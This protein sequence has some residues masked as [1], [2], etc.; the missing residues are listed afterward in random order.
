MVSRERLNTGELEEEEE[1]AAA[2]AA[3]AVEEEEEEEEN[4]AIARTQRG[5]THNWMGGGCSHKALMN[6]GKAADDDDADDDEDDA[7]DDADD[8][9]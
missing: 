9:C 3:A 4:A 2:A 1:C 6:R 8:A 5:H 7:D